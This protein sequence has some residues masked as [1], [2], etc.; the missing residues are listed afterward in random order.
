MSL[1]ES[2]KDN[3]KCSTG[4]KPSPEFLLYFIQ[5]LTEKQLQQFYFI[6]HV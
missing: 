3:Y 1:A 5:P 2:L 4:D 6:P